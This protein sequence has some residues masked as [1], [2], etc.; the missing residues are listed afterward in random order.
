[1]T[2]EERKRRNAVVGSVA[3]VHV[4]TCEGCE[5]V[6]QDATFDFES[7]AVEFAQENQREDGRVLC[8]WCAD[9]TRRERLK[10]A[11]E[12]HKAVEEPK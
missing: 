4:V 11:A 3:Q 1:M 10:A 12:K 6:V 9:P 8:A 7:E 2:D 5:S